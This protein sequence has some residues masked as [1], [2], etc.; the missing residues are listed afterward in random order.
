M[1]CSSSSSSCFFTWESCWVE[2][3]ARSIVWPLGE[4]ILQGT[5]LWISLSGR[6]WR[7]CAVDLKLELEI[8]NGTE[9]E[10]KGGIQGHVVSRII[11]FD[12]GDF[13]YFF[14]A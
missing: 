3:E 5:W 2:R 7:G 6:R 1:R 4:A 11:I 12:H 14:A 13:D 8:W 9:V 10:F